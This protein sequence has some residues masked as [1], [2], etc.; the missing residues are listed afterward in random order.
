[1][2]IVRTY[3]CIECFHRVEL[4]LSAEEWDNPP[5]ACPRCSVITQQ[6]FKPFAI[7]GSVSGKANA[8]TE[9]ILANDYHVAD[10]KREGR[11]QGT[12]SV[13]YKDAATV[14]AQS[15]SWGATNQ[16]LEQ[17]VVLGRQSRLQHGSGLDILQA[18]LKSGAEPDLIANS[19]R[20][21]IR[22]Y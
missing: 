18:N 16:A 19:K 2:P 9:D 21:A 11:Q 8:I 5:P 3:Q 7:G 10:I 22:I 4:T 17:A 15:G 20:R 12:P 1:M 14:P 6:E 13:R